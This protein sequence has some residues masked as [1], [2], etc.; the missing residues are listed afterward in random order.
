MRPDRLQRRRQP[1]ARFAIEAERV[2]IALGDGPVVVDVHVR[3]DEGEGELVLRPVPGRC[4]P[5][6]V[7]VALEPGDVLGERGHSRYTYRRPPRLL[8]PRAPGRRT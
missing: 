2:P 1:F 6:G 8:F 7:E 3:Q 4:G 5:A